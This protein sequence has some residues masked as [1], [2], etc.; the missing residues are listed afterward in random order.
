M[1]SFSTRNIHSSPRTYVGV[2][3][4]SAIPYT[5][6]RRAPASMGRRPRGSKKL[7]RRGARVEGGAEVVGTCCGAD[8][9]SRANGPSCWP[10]PEHHE[11]GSYAR[12]VK[13]A[14]ESAGKIRGTS[15]TLGNTHRIPRGPYR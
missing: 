9:T 11:L 7:F 13:C 3:G 4:C 5:A 14:K 12:L 2:I 10:Y 15:G 1:E 6:Q 8:S